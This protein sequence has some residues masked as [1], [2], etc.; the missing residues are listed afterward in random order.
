MTRAVLKWL[1]AFWRGVRAVSGD[2]AYERYAAHE[3]AHHPERKPMDR[4]T[5]YVTEQHRRF[6]GG[7]TRCC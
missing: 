1:D 6:S 7:P 2:D 4:R 5:F 3:R